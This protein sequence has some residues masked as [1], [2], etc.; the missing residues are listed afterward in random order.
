MKTKI[1]GPKSYAVLR[2]LKRL[3]GG[4]GDG[5][6]FV[7]SGRGKGCY[8]KD[9]DG[10]EF[11]DFA[12]QIAANPLGYNHKK[13]SKVVKRYKSFLVK[14]AGQDFAVKEHLQMLEEVLSIS[15]GM[16]S[17]F[18]INSGAEA[19][20]NAIK[21]CMRKRKSKYGISFDGA[22]HGRTLGALSCTQ[23]KAVHKKG[24]WSF[25]MKVM[26]YDETMK[27]KLQRIFEKDAKKVGFVI[28][29]ALQGEGGYRIPSNKM[30]KSLYLLCKKHKVPLISDE[31]QSGVGRTGKWWAH[32][33]YAF[34]PNVITSAKALQVG[35][36]ISTKNM[37]PSEGGAISST[38][39]GGHTLDLA[40]GVET[41]KV[42]KD[43]KLLVHNKKMGAYIVR[44]L[45]NVGVKNARGRGLMCAFDLPT[46]KVRNDV[47][48]EMIKKG[49]VVLAAGKK[50]VR[51]IP[52]Y[53]VTEKEVDKAVKV[54]EEAVK[55][56]SKKGF[57][58][59]GKVCEITGC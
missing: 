20:E 19:V 9:L 12:S 27:D 48:L 25:P 42:I 29:E 1:P 22:F 23:S 8:F 50:S 7:H 32:E 6:P 41:I 3:N 33:H 36:V 57:K 13:L 21:I 24:Y 35:A 4:W 28:I 31:V 40:L 39:G 52:P 18:L 14:Y 15:K 46:A 16:D 49:V 55:K 43:Q 37:F 51:L 5:M 11:L 53:I 45:E 38:W 59:R 2:K 30:M 26:P 58:H 56:C 44:S 10:N 54:I 17:A 47:V 34:K